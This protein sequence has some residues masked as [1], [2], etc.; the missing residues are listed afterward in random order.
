[1][2]ES[3]RIRQRYLGGKWSKVNDS[4]LRDIKI[5]Q[6]D[7]I[8]NTEKDVNSKI[9]EIIA[10]CNKYGYLKRVESIVTIEEAKEFIRK[11]N[12]GEAPYDYTKNEIEKARIIWLRTKMLDINDINC[13]YVYKDKHGNY[14]NLEHIHLDGVIYRLQRCIKN[15]LASKE[16]TI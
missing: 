4:Q 16:V 1:M 7:E 9:E 10:F 13:K 11:V 15:N 2:G 6:L 5:R 14:I 12:S 3:D 8:Y